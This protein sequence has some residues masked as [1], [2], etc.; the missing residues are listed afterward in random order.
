MNVLW[1]VQS[2]ITSLFNVSVREK[3]KTIISFFEDY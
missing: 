3:C 2:N 1:S